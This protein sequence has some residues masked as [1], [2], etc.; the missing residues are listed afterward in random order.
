MCQFFNY[1]FCLIYGMYEWDYD[2]NVGQFYV[3]VYMFYCFIFQCEIV[4]EVVGNIVVCVMEVEY[5]VF[6]IWFVMFIIDQVGI[7]V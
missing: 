7:F 3:V 5:W 1:C 2:F 4:V 6:F